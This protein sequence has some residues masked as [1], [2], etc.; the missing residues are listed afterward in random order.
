MPLFVNIPPTEWVTDTL[1]PFCPDPVA[2][3]AVMLDIDI[4]CKLL[5]A[6]ILFVTVSAA[7]I[8][9]TV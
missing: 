5:G 6:H 1:I 7:G 8:A 9:F 2:V 3:V 4:H